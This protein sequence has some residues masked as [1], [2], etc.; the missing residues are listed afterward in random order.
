[1]KITAY[2]LYRQQPRNLWFKA[3]QAALWNRRADLILTEYELE[4]YAARFRGE[5]TGAYWVW[6]GKM[7]SKH[8][9]N[10]CLWDIEFLRRF[11]KLYL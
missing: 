3:L 10:P 2:L 7:E 11:I 9:E 5:T 6:G 1:M 4:R 8:L